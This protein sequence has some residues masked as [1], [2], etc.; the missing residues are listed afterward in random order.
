MEIELIFEGVESKIIQFLM[1]DDFTS[2][3]VV[4]HQLHCD[5]WQSATIELQ[6]LKYQISWKASKASIRSSL[7]SS[8][9]FRQCNKLIGEPGLAWCGLANPIIKFETR[10]S[11]SSLHYNIP[12][13]PCQPCPEYSWNFQLV[14]FSIYFTH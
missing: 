8:L 12:I 3:S 11:L 4:V 6:F 1:E 13:N 5:V 14:S 9:N 7:N 2:C 10:T